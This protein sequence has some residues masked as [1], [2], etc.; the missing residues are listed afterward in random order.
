[1]KCDKCKRKGKCEDCGEEI[2]LPDYRYK[3]PFISPLNDPN[4]VWCS[5]NTTNL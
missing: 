5:D 1:M 3:E 4:K 2:I